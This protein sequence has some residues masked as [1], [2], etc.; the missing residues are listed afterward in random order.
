[1]SL[2]EQ[3]Y[4]EH[5]EYEWSR[6]ERHRVEYG[7]TMRALAEHLPAAPAK[8]A[9]VGGS[10]GRYSIELARRG[11]R[12]TLVDLSA[13]CL[14]FARQKAAEAGVQL[15]DVVKADGR[16]L[17]VFADESFD[18]VLLMGPL[19]HLLE[20]DQRLAA[21]REGR[22][23]LRPGGAVVASFVGVNSI[24][25]FGL[26]RDIEYLS[27]AREE[28]DRI[29][30]TGVYRRPE[31]NAGFP[32]AWFA[33]P[34]EVPPLMAEAGFEQVDFLN[35]EALAFEM[36]AKV[37]AAPEPL[38]QQWLD[39]LYRLSRDASTMGCGGHLVFV[40]RKPA[41]SLGHPAIGPEL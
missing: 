9:D 37:N 29:L 16:N 14:E 31:G 34:H 27:R 7:L 39:L 3:A 24:L 40:G 2:V 13:K 30:A 26:A 35:S 12:V 19:Y 8:I 23:V 38:H 4:D 15:G 11:Y 20:H 33:R 17:S 41:G 6:L 32:D 28:I 18:A 25:Q 1:M 22:R 36:E 21:A 10:V 5:P